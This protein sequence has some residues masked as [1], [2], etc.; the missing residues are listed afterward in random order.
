MRL[1]KL[2]GTGMVGSM[3]MMTVSLVAVGLVLTPGPN[4]V[5]L[6]A[7]TVAQG[8]TAGMVSLLGMAAGFAVYLI[9]SAAGLTAVL[10]LIPYLLQGI[11]AAGTTY[12]L[13]LAWHTL[14]T[15]STLEGGLQ[16]EAPPSRLFLM[17]LATNLL[18]PT[19]AVLYLTVLPQFIEADRGSVAMQALILGSLQAAIMLTVNCLVVLAAG[20]LTGWLAGHPRLLR[21]QRWVTSTVL[22]AV[23]VQIL[24]A[25]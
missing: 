6:V 7:R 24:A 8:R 16:A 3:A 25:G 12:L 9:G 19:V 23:A 10:T 1:S 4:T 13:W 11:K 17:G 18:N 14:R 22:S 15:P 2:E 21:A 20:R 5:Y